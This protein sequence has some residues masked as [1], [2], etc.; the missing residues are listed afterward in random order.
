MIEVVSLTKSFKIHKKQ[1]GFGGAVKSLFSRAWEDKFALKGV[2]L[3]VS[4]GELIGLV[5]ANGAGKT[6]LVKALAGIIHPTSGT[7]NVNGFKPYERKNEFRK[8]IGLLMGQKA[9]LWWDLTASDCFILLKEIYQIP[10]NVFTENLNELTAALGVEKLLDIQVR[11]LSLGERM[12]MELIASLLHRPKVLFLDEPTLGLDITSQRAIRKFLLQYVEKYKPAVLLTSHYMQDIEELCKRIV[13]IREGEFVYD[14]PLQE[15]LSHYATHKV[16]RLRAASIEE[17]KGRISALRPNYQTTVTEEAL[18]VS[19]EKDDMQKFL[20]ELL[21]GGAVE[22]IL[23]EDEDIATII[24]SLMTKG[25][26]HR[27]AA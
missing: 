7:L 21:A 15:V 1:S 8:Q 25:S 23:I 18:Q 6:T 26:H 27:V 16:L 22:D 19:V 2:T 11:R 12:K 10:N 13:I 4:E 3:K 24:E 5:G 17:L 14:G 20:S 9:Q